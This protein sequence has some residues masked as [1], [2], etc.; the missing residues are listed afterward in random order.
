MLARMQGKRDPFHL[1]T[2]GGVV[3]YENEYVGYSKK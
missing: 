1:Y 2:I 3:N